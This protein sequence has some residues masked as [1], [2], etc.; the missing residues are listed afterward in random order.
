[1]GLPSEDVWGVSTRMVF[2]PNPNAKYIIKVVRGFDQSTGLPGNASGT[3]DY[4]PRDYWQLHWKAEL[5]RRHM[6]SGFFMKDAWG[7]YDFYRQ[8]NTTFPEQIKIDY[9]YLLGGTGMFG[10]VNDEDRASKI[11]VRALYRTSDENSPEIEYLD[12]LN[13]WT[14]MIVAYFTYQF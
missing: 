3:L 8:F 2:N 4:A 11:G 1:M 5:K 14:A 12:G 6:L 10:S 7:P 9:A 13:D